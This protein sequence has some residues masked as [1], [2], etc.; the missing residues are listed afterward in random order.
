MFFDGG[1]SEP[2]EAL[3][4]A[5]K[6]SLHAGFWPLAAHVSREK[7]VVKLRAESFLLQLS[8]E[9]SPAWRPAELLKLPSLLLLMQTK[10]TVVRTFLPVDLMF[11]LRVRIL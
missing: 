2:L 8:D 1:Q 3:T 5:A 7:A 11:L 9:L 4:K 6:L 10:W